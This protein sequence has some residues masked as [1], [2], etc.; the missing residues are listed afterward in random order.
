[1]AGYPGGSGGYPGASGGY[2]G[3]TGGGGGLDNYQ[4][5]QH[6]VD[7]LIQ[8]KTPKAWMTVH[9]IAAGTVKTPL[10]L[11]VSAEIVV[12]GL[13]RNLLNNP[14]EIE[15][16]IVALID[17]KG[18]L[19]A[20]S[21]AACLSAI[22]GISGAAFDVMTG[23]KP[24]ATQASQ[25]GFGGPGGMMGPGM[26]MS[27]PGMGMS[28][29][30]MGSRP[31][32]AGITPPS[33]NA[34]A[35][36]VE[37]DPGMG[38]LA[39]TPSTAAALAGTGGQLP[40]AV[41]LSAAALLWSP[42]SVEAIAA[43]L[44]SST[45]LNSA[46]PLLLLAGTIP[47]KRIRE[48]EL[49]TF[50]RL[51]S[52]GADALNNAGVFSTGAHDPGV[53]VVLKS[54]PRQK[55]PRTQEGQVASMDS[56]TSASQQMVLSF[57]DRLRLLSSQPGK[58]TPT[59]DSFPV[60]FHRG[61]V[62]EFSGMMTLPGP[63]GEALKES[64]PSETRIYYARIPFSPQ[65]AKDQEDAADHYESKTSGYRRVDQARGVLWIDGVKGSQSGIKRSLDVVIQ[66]SS[67]GG[68]GFGGGADTSL[69]SPGLGG[70]G[71]G[72]GAGGSFTIE[73]IVVE[74]SDPKKGSEGAEQASANP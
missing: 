45:D 2:L 21:R 13:F 49:A 61:G 56:W 18:G 54:L 4:L 5:V 8:N 6:I 15:Q 20:E 30:G 19:P 14:A 9:G 68:Q 69:G 63:A 60:R 62:A 42:R 36:F 26:G 10:D 28:A 44:E 58:L 11:S 48:A 32:G 51:H 41:L 53:L 33:A 73:I 37:A 70:P 38:T 27:A 46:T 64:A 31:P 55:P 67:T 16:V 34:G 1:M 12:Q 71:A 72:R 39:P 47:N 35:G 59:G 7:G 23:L 74:T 43:Q 24:V 40:E 65:R 22:T 50:A 25:S 29:P 52:E 66:A 17:G 3:S 57:R